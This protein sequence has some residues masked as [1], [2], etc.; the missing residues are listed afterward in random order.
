MVAE[1]GRWREQTGRS[2][3]R[4]RW[5][6]RVAPGSMAQGCNAPPY[7]EANGGAP[8]LPYVGGSA[9]A[10]VAWTAARPQSVIVGS[11]YSVAR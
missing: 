7:A 5:L 6:L 8:T 3:F 9:L 1:L 10:M 2:S 4:R 11:R